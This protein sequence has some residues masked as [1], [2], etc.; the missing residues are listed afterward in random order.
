ML[1]NDGAYIIGLRF[2]G[3][4]AEMKEAIESGFV[5]EAY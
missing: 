2:K 5:V 1:D 4:K 3:S